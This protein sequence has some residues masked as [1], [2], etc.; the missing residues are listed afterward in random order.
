MSTWMHYWNSRQIDD[1]MQAGVIDHIASDQFGCLKPG[2]RV[3]I[4][5]SAGDTLFTIGYVDVPIVL[6]L[7]EA[8]MMHPNAWP[9]KWHVISSKTN[10]VGARRVE[11][12]P[13]MVRALRLESK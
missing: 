13:G 5:G 6:T 8:Q 1:A 9:A 7:A 11:L 4:V 10:A 3:W 12:P 2:D